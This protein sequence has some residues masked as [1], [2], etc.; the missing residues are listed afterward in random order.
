MHPTN[1]TS[2]KPLTSPLLRELV[3]QPR[4]SKTSQLE[5]HSKKR[6]SNSRQRYS[7]SKSD[8]NVLIGN[9]HGFFEFIE[10]ECQNYATQIYMIALSL[11]IWI[12]FKIKETFLH[13]LEELE[14]LGLGLILS[15]I[16]HLL[17]T[18]NLKKKLFQEKKTNFHFV[19]DTI[20]LLSGSIIFFI[21]G[22]QILPLNTTLSVYY[23]TFVIVIL[24][25]TM[26]HEKEFSVSHILLAICA[27]IGVV[28][29]FLDSKE[30]ESVRMTNFWLLYGITIVGISAV[31]L[32][33][34]FIKLSKVTEPSLLSFKGSLAIISAFAMVLD[35]NF[36]WPT[37]NQ[38]L[39]IVIFGA[40]IYVGSVLLTRS[41]QL[42]GAGEISPF[43]LGHASV[44]P[45]FG[46]LFSKNG[47]TIE[48]VGSLVT[49][50]SLIILMLITPKMKKT[51]DT[52]SE[53]LYQL[54]STIVIELTERSLNT[55]Y[56]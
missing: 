30:E 34:F 42:T 41:L 16:L 24:L 11:L 3:K 17:L 33:G 22:L 26:I 46:W 51:E 6:S 27:Y 28:L 10:T 44:G 13:D 29:V 49:Q 50:G 39:V 38:T 43:L 20:I 55:T 32:A 54:D 15:F 2:S 19:K 48:A 31:F 47:L 40:L 7:S 21:Y 52:T 35:K 25:E 36:E 12:L 4:C 23:S 45:L 9:F 56:N 14:T 8:S 5:D 1:S 37:F 18:K 53:N